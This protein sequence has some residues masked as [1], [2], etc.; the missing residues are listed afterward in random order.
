MSVLLRG[1][2]CG[3]SLGAFQPCGSARKN[4]TA[5]ASTAAAAASGS[6][7]STWAPMTGVDMLQGYVRMPTAPGRS[8]P[9]GDVA[10]PLPIGMYG[11]V[12]RVMGDQIGASSLCPVGTLACGT[13]SRP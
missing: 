4:C 7:E 11:C 6:T 5:A 8:G 2:A 12:L 9:F 10:Q 3:C 13:Q 1:A